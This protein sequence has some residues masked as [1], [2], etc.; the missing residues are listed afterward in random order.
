MASV[1]IR[2]VGLVS[3]CR[4]GSCDKLSKEFGVLLLSQ[5]Q[6]LGSP[7]TTSFQAVMES[8]TGQGED[9]VGPNSSFPPVQQLGGLAAQ[10]ASAPSP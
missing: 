6:S 9:S 7:P 2:P 4:T 10:P 5:P 1:L 3:S 8:L